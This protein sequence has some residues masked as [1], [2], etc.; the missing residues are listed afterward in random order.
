MGRTAIR[1]LALVG[2]VGAVFAFGPQRGSTPA[3]HAPDDVQSARA[4][5]LG[6]TPTT[7]S[8]PGTLVVDLQDGASEAD[9]V[10]VETALGHDLDWIHDLARDEALVAGTVPDLADALS[11]LA[12]HPLVEV[13]EPELTMEAFGRPNDPMLEKQWNLIDIGMEHVWTTGATGRGVV[14]AVVDTGVSKVEDLQG[15]HVLKGAS[16][17]PGADT[18]ADDQGHGTHVAGTIAQTTNNG[19]GVAGVAPG[20]TI[21]PVKVLSGAGFGSS[22]WIAAGIDYAVD[23]GADVINLSLGGGYSSIIHNAIKKARDHGVIVVA[24]AGNSGRQGVGYPGAL[25]ETI[26][27]AATGPGGDRAPYSSWGKGVDIAAPGGDKRTSGGGILQDTIDGKGGH[28]YAE[29]QGTSMAT[30]HVAGAAAVLLGTGMAP[31]A[32][33][34][35]LL[36]T[37]R[38]EGWNEK[39]GHGRL[40]LATAMGARGG[41]GFGKIRFLLGA[42][43]ALLVAQL[44]STRS[45]YQLGSA[46]VSA[47]V[48][49]GLFFVPAWLLGAAGFLASPALEWP[50]AFVGIGFV[51]FPLWLSVAAPAV[52]GFTLGAFRGTRPLAAG[53][54]TGT[55][56][57]LLHAAATGAIAPSWLPSSLATAWLGVN[58]ILCL[59]V[60]LGLAGAQKLDEQELR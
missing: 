52:V 18:A 29:F 34:R 23:E 24:A 27:V 36:D 50:A 11:R 16:F 32:V 4:R 6:E 15:T 58:G 47:T 25:E 44:A 9:L 60:A 40:D 45:S 46:A 14:V 10:A 21:L 20:A 12:G 17:V 38:G 48:A 37:A 7:A 49:G 5:L 13:V 41:V 51:T 53:L 33:E 56:A 22:A 28:V 59:L 42:V 2:T 31:D 19:V 55:A 39:F 43:L 8:M 30:P 1:W 57:Y 54:A 3:V 35:T 26:G